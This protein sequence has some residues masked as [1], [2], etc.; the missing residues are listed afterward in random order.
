MRLFRSSILM[1]SL[2]A[3]YG[4]GVDEAVPEE[5]LGTTQSPLTS[6]CVQQM[7]LGYLHSC[8]VKTN[9][10]LWCWG[11]NWVGELGLG[12]TST[13]GV[14][15][16]SQVTALGSGVA[17]VNGGNHHTC[18]RKTD[19]TIWCWGDNTYGQLGDGTT[20]QRTSPVK[21]ASL[22]TNNAEVVAGGDHTC[23]RKTDNSLYCWGSN[24]VGQ[25][26]RV[27]R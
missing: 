4:C 17:Q 9:G 1:L 11:Y 27:Y 8:V 5:T 12:T 19:G 3:V 22:G 14:P 16:P 7:D 25:L 26:A 15:T 24:N 2:L 21:V 6:G 10:T 20:T 13:S 23:A 18:A